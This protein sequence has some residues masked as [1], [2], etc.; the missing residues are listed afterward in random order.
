MSG[1]KKAT[2]TAAKLR[3]GFAGPS[4]SGKT[5][6]AI[7]LAMQIADGG[8]VAV[9]DTERGSASLYEGETPDGVPFDFD[10]M[11]LQSFEP[12]RYEAAIREAAKGGYS[13]VV[14]DSL[15]HAWNGVG[16]MLEQVDK[17]GGQ[18]G[19]WRNVTPQHNALVD[20][21]LRAPMHVIITL[22]T[23]TEYVIVENSKGKKE[24]QKIGLAPVFRDGIEYECTCFFDVDIDHNVKVSKTRCSALDGKLFHK[25]GPELARPLLDWLAGAPAPAPEEPAPVP[26]H[27]ES[28]TA[29]QRRFF[30]ELGKLGVEY[31]PLKA[32]LATKGHPK[33]SAMTQVRRVK[34]VEALQAGHGLRTEF[35]A[36]LAQN[37]QTPAQAK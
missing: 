3:I 5:Y 1:F 29:D 28:W 25:P 7:R 13:V 31:E 30:A 23:K 12:G 8:R 14:I 6:T 4:G 24:P 17:A 26:E 36:W 27:D 37:T 32:F 33:P 11:E 2:R 18:F 20:A 22:R 16:G 19:A 35:D 9:I 10:V 21:L 34:L 15:S